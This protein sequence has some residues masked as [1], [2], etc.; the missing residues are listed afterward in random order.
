M[1]SHRLVVIAFGLGSFIFPSPALRLFGVA[2]ATWTG[3]LA[4]YGNWIRM[5]GSKEILAEGKSEL[6]NEDC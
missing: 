4:L 3:W 2:C 6:I 1:L 5:R